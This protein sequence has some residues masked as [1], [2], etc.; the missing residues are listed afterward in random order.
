[1]SNDK[2]HLGLYTMPPITHHSMATWRHALNI[3]EGRGFEFDRAAVWQYVAQL[4]ERA[5]FDFFFAADTEGVYRAYQDSIEPAV[6]FAAQVPVFDQT[7]TLSFV[8]AAT[9]NLG[10]VSTLSINGTPPYVAAR[11][12]ATLDHLSGGRA[13]WNVVTS[14][15]KSAAQNLGKDDQLGHDA[16]YDRAEEYMDVCYQLWNSWDTD[17]ITFDK[18]KGEFANPAKVSEIHFEGD[19][20][21]CRGPLNVHRSPQGV[22]VIAQAGSSVRG[23]AFA[24]KHAELVF[25]VQPFREG[26]KLYHDELKSTMERFGRDPD[27]CKVMFSFQPVVGET[28][29]IARAKAELHNSLVP[30]EG[31][32]TIFS[33]HTSYDWSVHDPGKP[34]KDLRTDVP[35]IQGLV[36]MYTRV[37]EGRDVTLADVARAH[38]RGVGSPQVVGT[39]A[40]IADWMQETMEFVG[41]DGFMLSPLYLPGSLEEFIDHVV[42]ELRRR[43]LVRQDYVPGGTLRDNLLAF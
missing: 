36:D 25:T 8:A 3:P 28:E 39:A 14:F 32:M 26:M 23:I 4:A 34:L 5:K 9:Q 17:A 35:G 24:A 33:G 7:V 16:R 21:K 13:G 31:G 1:M 18:E 12:F 22:P 30:L 11:K 37:A 41:G 40:Q 6:R 29:E 27:S 2:F 20:Y 42:P 38:G 15:Q 19:H 43:G 10:V